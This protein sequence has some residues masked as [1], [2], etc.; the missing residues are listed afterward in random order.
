MSNEISFE[1]PTE[2]ERDKPITIPITVVL[3]RPLKVRGIHAKFHGAE[4]TK[5]TYTTTSS[6]GKGRTTTQTHTAVQHVDVTTQAV[7]IKGRITTYS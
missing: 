3:D 6:D 2:I 7:L 5:A 1:A 4:E